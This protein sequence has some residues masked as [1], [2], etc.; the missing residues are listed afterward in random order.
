MFAL[1]NSAIRCTLVVFILLVWL[2]SIFEKKNNVRTCAY[3]NRG[4]DRLFIPHFYQEHPA[5][6]Q[7]AQPKS[8]PGS[9]RYPILKK[10]AAEA[11]P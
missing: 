6:R 11:A 2:E 5:C 4:H 10:G 9:A 8:K 1:N 3:K 7:P